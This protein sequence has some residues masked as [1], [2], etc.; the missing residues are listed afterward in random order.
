MPKGR[1]VKTNVHN[2]KWAPMGFIDHKGTYLGHIVIRRITMDAPAQFYPV[3]YSGNIA[4]PTGTYF[5]DYM[6]AK[7]YLIDFQKNKP[8]TEKL[9]KCNIIQDLQ[10]SVL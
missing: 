1:P 5:L 7:Q 2:V 10:P 3:P 9:R 6:E 4:V 8:P